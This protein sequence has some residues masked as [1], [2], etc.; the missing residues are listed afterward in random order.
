MNNTLSNHICKKPYWGHPNIALTFCENKYDDSEY[1]AEYYN[2]ISA[3]SYI[4][5][6]AY[7]IRGKHSDLGYLTILLGIGTMIMHST[8]RKYGQWMDEISMLL[9]TSLVIHKLRNSSV[10]VLLSEIYMIMVLYSYTHEYSIVFVLIFFSNMLSI[11][12]L[13]KDKVKTNINLVLYVI[14]MGTSMMFWFIDQ[15]L[16]EYIDNN[17]YHAIW[18]VG[19]ALSMF[20]GYLELN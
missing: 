17:Y 19:T 9:I 13:I 12:Y 11:G 6:G 20:F 2:T 16:C 5:V 7:F 3:I 8:L 1:I 10:V 4:L 18:H 14:L 15:I